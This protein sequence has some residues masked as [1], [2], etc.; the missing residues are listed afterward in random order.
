MAR[1]GFA[2]IERFGAQLEAML[3]DGP[4]DEPVSVRPRSAGRPAPRTAR[5]AART[6]RLA[7][8]EAELAAR[9]P[10]EG[11]VVRGVDVARV[12]A[13]ATGHEVKWPS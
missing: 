7:E 1:N 4:A 3:A 9:L 11:A 5:S 8:V 2:A 12:V 10:E 6:S 13:V